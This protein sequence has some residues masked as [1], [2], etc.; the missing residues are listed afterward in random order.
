MNINQD[1][2]I[3]HGHWCLDRLAR[4]E[5]LTRQTGARERIEAIMDQRRANIKSG[6]VTS[7]ISAAL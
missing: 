2:I 1:I 6:K 5:D 7:C 3:E 4:P